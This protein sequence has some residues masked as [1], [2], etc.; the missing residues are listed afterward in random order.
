MGG[1]IDIEQ[2]GWRSVIYDN[3][4][5]L[6]MTEVKCRDLPDSDWGDFRCRCAVDSSWSV[7]FP[8]FSGV[9]TLSK[10]GQIGV[11]RHFLGNEC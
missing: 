2:K 9:V 7:D 8:H 3:A 10:A 1:S 6:L 4:R 5:D 11:S